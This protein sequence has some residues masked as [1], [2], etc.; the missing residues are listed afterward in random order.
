MTALALLGT[1]LVLNVEYPD[2]IE[3][4]NHLTHHEFVI[5]SYSGFSL[6]SKKRY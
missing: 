6:F 5:L 3:T 2:D 1:R 4:K